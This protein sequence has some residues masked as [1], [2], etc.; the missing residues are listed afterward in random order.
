[1]G[2]LI[3][4]ILSLKTITDNQVLEDKLSSLTSSMEGL[5]LF[6]SS[7]TGLHSFD[8][9][10]CR[11]DNQIDDTVLHVQTSE[12]Q[13]KKVSDFLS[14]KERVASGVNSENKEELCS[15]FVAILS[16]YSENV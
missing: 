12:P 2:S 11:V 10:K 13:S 9:L 1:M 3:F 8:E 6:L 15:L 5:V 7:V 4:K 16:L 14:L